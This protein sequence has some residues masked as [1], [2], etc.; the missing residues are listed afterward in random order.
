MKDRALEYTDGWHPTVNPS[1]RMAIHHLRFIEVLGRHD[2]GL[3]NES[4]RRHGGSTLRLIRFRRPGEFG[5]I[6]LPG[7]LEWVPWWLPAADVRASKLV[8]GIYVTALDDDRPTQS[9]RAV[10][11][12]VLEDFRS[13]CGSAGQSTVGEALYQVMQRLHTELVPDLPQISL[14]S[15]T[16]APERGILADAL[17]NVPGGL[18]PALKRWAC[19]DGIPL[20]SAIAMG[21]GKGDEPIRIR[22]TADVARLEAE[23]LHCANPRG[24]YRRMARRNLLSEDDLIQ[25]MRSGRLIPSSRLTS[26]AEVV[27]YAQGWQVRHFGNTYGRLAEAGRL[28]GIDGAERIP[29]C[30]DNL[31]PWHWADLHCKD[32]K[33]P[34]TYPLHLLDAVACGPEACATVPSLVRQ[35][36]REGVPV[37]LAAKESLDASI[38]AG[39][40]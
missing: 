6:E 12:R 38:F 17:S 31:D 21:T 3:L 1:A 2:V 14:V 13:A 16:R 26:L 35:S 11:A 36:K 37:H 15:I 28:L 25:M 20:L 23:D 30:V 8:E 18:L 33:L 34:W 19:K 10:F 5:I 9:E 4:P 32:Q 22:F 24:K 29:C 7:T 27:L 40:A 39:G